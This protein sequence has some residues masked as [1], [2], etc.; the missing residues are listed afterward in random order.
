[1][2]TATPKLCTK[3]DAL[4]PVPELATEETE[5]CLACAVTLPTDL[6][7][8]EFEARFKPIPK[9]DGSLYYDSVYPADKALIDAAFAERRLWTMHDGEYDTLYYWSGAHFVNR[10]GYLITEVPVPEGEEFIVEVAVD[11]H[12]LCCP[13][14]E[15]EE[16]GVPH[17]RYVEISD[18]A[19]CCAECP[20]LDGEDA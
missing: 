8:A 5:L 7:E 3:C 11:E 1:M 2:S 16:D 18:G 14:C 10:L 6:T 9:A 13:W 12:S 15:R 4:I 19:P 20:G 17:E